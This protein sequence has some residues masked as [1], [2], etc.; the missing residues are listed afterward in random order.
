MAFMQFNQNIGAILIKKTCISN[1]S[2]NQLYTI[3]LVMLPLVKYRNTHLILIN[4]PYQ[5]IHPQ[6]AESIHLILLNKLYQLTKINTILS[7]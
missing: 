5:L 6:Y 1:K 3:K 4:K 2:L 7:A